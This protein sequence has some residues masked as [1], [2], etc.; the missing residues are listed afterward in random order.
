MAFVIEEDISAPELLRRASEHFGAGLVM[1][2]A[3][4]LEGSV[5]AHMIA[6][7]NLPI[8]I[9][10]LDTGL[11][12]EETRLAWGRLEKSLGL[13]IEGLRPELTVEAQEAEHG[14]QLW[15]R[16]PDKCC[17]LRKVQPLKQLLNPATAWITGIRREQSPER[18]N[19]PKAGWEPRFE[20]TKINPLAD[21]TQ[22]AVRAYLEQHEVPYNP[23]F[24][25]GYPSIGCAP[26]TQPVAA[27]ED[28][29]AGRWA[30]FQKRECGLHWATSNT[31]TVSLRHGSRAS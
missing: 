11:L 5:I 4:G 22:A 1:T 7:E 16:A 31:Q 29:R 30:G 19:A 3:F 28:E 24:D 12:F 10:T 8:R 17:D 13:Q 2:T 26:C 20:V 9:V 23:M 15:A 18:R 6:T 25:E 14:P 21:W 27:G